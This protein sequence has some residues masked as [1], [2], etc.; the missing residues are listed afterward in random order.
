M[1]TT[2]TKV[3]VKAPREGIL[4]DC[5]PGDRL[6]VR[7]VEPYDAKT[8]TLE[9]VKVL[10]RG[11][12]AKPAVKKRSSPMEYLKSKQTGAIAAAAY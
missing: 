10:S 6:E 4:K 11:G 1:T 2:A 3:R 8:V 12:A 5:R 7:S 9:V